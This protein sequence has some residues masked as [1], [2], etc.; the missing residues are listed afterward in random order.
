[1]VL[2]THRL[3]LAD[4][5]KNHILAHVGPYRGGVLKE[6]ETTH[7]H[8]WTHGVKLAEKVVETTDSTDPKNQSEQRHPNTETSA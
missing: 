4:L 6:S 7:R 1:M 3:V 2:L 8:R 5:L